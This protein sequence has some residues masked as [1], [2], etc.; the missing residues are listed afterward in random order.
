MTTTAASWD[1]AGLALD[2][3]SGPVGCAYV[4]A[5]GELDVYTGAA[6]CQTVGEL[7]ASGRTTITLDLS[8]LSFIDSA[9]H[10]SIDTMAGRAERLGGEVRLCGCSPRVRRFLDLTTAVRLSLPI[11]GAAERDEAIAGDQ[12]PR[13]VRF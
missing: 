4:A 13:S 12:R 8:A 11:T 6:L 5:V 10:R 9:G 7:L 2:V 3:V 1:G